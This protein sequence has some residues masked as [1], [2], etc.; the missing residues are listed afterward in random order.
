MSGW[1]Q[2]ILRWE[3]AH[4]P[5][6]SHITGLYLIAGICGLVDAAC[7]LSLGEVFAEM[8]TGNLLLFCFFVGTGHPIFQNAVY[9]IALG[10]F[11][12]GA[13][14]GGRIVRSAHGHTRLG[15][16]VEWVFLAAATILSVILA[17]DRAHGRDVVISL[18][19]FA[20]GMQNARAP[21]PWRARSG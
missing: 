19:A 15:F 11:A 2:P 10:A 3:R 4:G 8:M 7:F 18:L 16:A 9:L 13:I 6:I 17:R 21:P 1:L 20:M 14:A 12:F 5:L